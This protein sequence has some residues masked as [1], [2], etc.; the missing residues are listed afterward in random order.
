MS[1]LPTKIR[2]LFVCILVGPDYR[3]NAKKYI[4]LSKKLGCGENFEYLGPLYGQDKYDAIES[5][6]GHLMPS[7]SE[8]FSMSLLDIMACSKPSLLTSGC[9][10]NYFSEDDFF[11]RCEPYPQDIARGL[12]EFLAR[13]SDWVIMGQ[14]ARRMV[15]QKFNW[16]MIADVMLENY[17]RISGDK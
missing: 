5:A 17:S 9:A 11:V 6:D 4:L 8:G 7:F 1:L 2:A 10:M 12:E 13:Q 14:N 3:G 16:S 15:E